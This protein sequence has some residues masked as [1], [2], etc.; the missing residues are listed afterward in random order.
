M[1]RAEFLKRLKTYAK[2]NDLRYSFDPRK[3]RGSHGRVT[4]GDRFT[5]VKKGEF[6][7]GLLRKMLRDLDID[8]EEL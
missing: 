6:G 3:G 1:N 2:R 8:R 7:P 5:T 4:V